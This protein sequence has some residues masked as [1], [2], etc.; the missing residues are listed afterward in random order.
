MAKYRIMGD[1]QLHYCNVY[2][3]FIC[4]WYVASYGP[5]IP[6]YAQRLGTNETH[7]AYIFL[8]RAIANIF[9]SFLIKKML[10]VLT[11]PAVVSTIAVSLF[12]ALLA[13]SVWLSDPVLL[14]TLLIAS[15]CIVMLNI[16][17]V[18]FNFSIFDSEEGTRKI[19]LL[20]FVFGAGAMA[21]PF[22]TMFL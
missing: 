11:V 19:Q 6:F 9:G 16:V 8:V 17:L 1:Q 3:M 15:S 2:A 13:N 7:F 18:S 5:L 4:G 21:A 12:V 22:F 10:R 14:I 20:G